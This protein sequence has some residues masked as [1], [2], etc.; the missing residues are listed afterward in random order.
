MLIIVW[1]MLA[2]LVGLV[3]KRRGYH[4]H[5]FIFLSLFLSITFVLGLLN[6]IFSLVPV[7]MLLWWLG[8]EELKETDHAIR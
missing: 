4:P 1:I 7:L 5:W 3:A 8:P 2:V 6:F